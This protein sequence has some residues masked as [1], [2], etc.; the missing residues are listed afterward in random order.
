MEEPITESCFTDMQLF[1]PLDD[2]QEEWLDARCAMRKFSKGEYIKFAGEA[3]NYV[4]VLKKGRIK[5]GRYSDAGRELISVLLK[6][7]E[8]FGLLAILDDALE[9]FFYQALDDCEVGFIK[10]EDLKKLLQENAKL[11][12]I[13]MNLIG[14]K[15]LDAEAKNYDLVFTKIRG[16]MANLLLHLARDLGQKVGSETV[17]KHNLTHQE[18]AN[19]IGTSRQTATVLLNEFKSADVIYIIDRAKLIIRDMDYIKN[20]STSPK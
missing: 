8:V 10:A 16:R 18:M 14:K 2:G 12:F 4:Y 6:P 19:I 20:L 1:N 3:C 11:S 15:L 5:G 9:E 13:V 17:I 7:R